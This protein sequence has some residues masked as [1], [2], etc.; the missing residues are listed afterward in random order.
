MPGE[1]M[2]T[3]KYFGR[4]MVIFTSI[5]LLIGAAQAGS[6]GSEASRSESSSDFNET[7]R[8]QGPLLGFVYD[9]GVR[10]LRA[11]WGIPG[12]SLFGE[13]VAVPYGLAGIYFSPGQRYAIAEQR[14]E[15]PIGA[16]DLT[17]QNGDGL[18]PIAGAIY[19]PDIV[20]FSPNGSSVAMYSSAEGRLQVI[21]GLPQAP[22]LVREMTDNDLP[23]GVRFLALADDGSTLLEGSVG[24]EVYLLAGDG[25]VRFVYG[26]GDLAAMV[27]AP[28]SRDALIYD[29][30]EG[31]AVQLL[32]VLDNPSHAQLIGDLWE[33]NGNVALWMDAEKAVIASTDPSEVWQV[34]RRSLQVE[35]LQLPAE[36][37]VLQPLRMAGR[38]LFSHERGKPGWILDVSGE[39][40]SVHFVPALSSDKE[41]S[42][43]RTRKRQ[44]TRD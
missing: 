11:I 28:E 30:A 31:S 13:P 23:G 40:P 27:F 29:R 8:M 21:G 4:Y 44:V 36:P 2:D 7:T 1:N 12:A 6:A 26:A 5:C 15:V 14:A 42:R 10:E 9:S 43:Q 25:S 19:R 33:V 20:A 39:T 17:G 41:P 34:D 18:I 22:Q 3:A 32:H 24:S 35:N 16:M 37:T 38:L